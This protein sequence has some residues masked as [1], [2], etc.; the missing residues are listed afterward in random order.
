VSYRIPEDVIWLEADDEVRL[1]DSAAGEFR[2]LNRTAAEIW[3]LIADGETVAVAAESL[4]RKYAAGNAR[5]A[6]QLRAQVTEFVAALA[7]QGLIARV[8]DP[9]TEA[10]GD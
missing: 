6:D 3:T 10:S 1:Y 5:D 7:E 9:G 8:A 2:T 4:A